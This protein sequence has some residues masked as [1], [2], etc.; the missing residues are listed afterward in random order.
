MEQQTLSRSG[1]NTFLSKVF[2]WM[3]VGLAVTAATAGMV[4]NSEN[5]FYLIASNRFLFFGLIIGEFALVMVLSRNA[6]KFSFGTTI[7]LFMAYAI[8]NGLT[9]SVI[10][11]AYTSESIMT[12]FGITAVLFGVMALYGHVT[13]TDLSPFRSFLIMGVVGIVILS[14]ISIFIQSSSLYYFINL[15]GV[16]IFSGLTAYDLQKMK[17][18]YAYSVRQGGQLEGNIAITGA[19]TLYLDFINL[20]LFLIRLTGRRN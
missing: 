18:F 20:F 12:A 3:F 2:M 10:L 4:V 14:I 5:L 15:A 6:M 13:K 8:V 17:S 9:F 7:A 19:L 11:Y 1:L 16:V